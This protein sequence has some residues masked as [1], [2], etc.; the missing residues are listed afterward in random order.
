MLKF[1]IP[2]DGSEPCAQAVKQ[3]TRYLGWINEEVEINLLNVQPSIPYRKWVSDIV[4]RSEIARYQQEEGLTA[5]KRARKVLDD[6]KVRYQYSISVG[7][8]AEVITRYARE[9]GCDQIIM[10]S[11]GMGSVS[12]VVLG[13]VATRVLQFSPVPV[14]LM[15]KT[16]AA[17]RKN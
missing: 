10:G 1:L 5:L 12:S 15:K 13:S 11:R 2:V 6:A 14:L 16:G 3:L 9:K 17:R 4:G 7:E 8:P